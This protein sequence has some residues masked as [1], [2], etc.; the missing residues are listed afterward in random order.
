M[1]EQNNSNGKERNLEAILGNSFYQ[2]VLGSLHLASDENPYGQM[3]LQ[4]G[5]NNLNSLMG[6][7]DATEISQAAINKEREDGMIYTAP[8]EY[9]VERNVRGMFKEA[10]YGLSLDKLTK[11]LSSSMKGLKVDVRE[12]MKNLSAYD[13]LTGKKVSKETKEYVSGMVGTLEA[14]YTEYMARKQISPEALV[15]N[16]NASLDALNKKYAKGK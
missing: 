5:R 16:M 14:G 8:R 6:A 2:N 3:G 7:K 11:A 1:T 13:V 15:Q 9:Y 4:T 12:D 10:F